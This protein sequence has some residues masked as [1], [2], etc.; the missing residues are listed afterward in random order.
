MRFLQFLNELYLKGVE[1]TK[2]WPVVPNLKWVEFFVNPSKR[3]ME[4]A[5]GQGRGGVTAIRFVA[6]DKK[7]KLYVWNPLFL[8]H[9]AWKEIGDRRVYSND[10][11]ILAG[12]AEKQGGRWVMTSASSK[13]GTIDQWKWVEKWINISNFLKSYKGPDIGI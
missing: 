6:D 10:S 1:G 7:K 12:I 9:S 2:A 4:D 5:S 8:H 13:R 11:T 3:E